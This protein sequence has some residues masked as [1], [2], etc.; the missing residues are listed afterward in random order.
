MERLI[1]RDALDDLEP[2]LRRVHDTGATVVLTGDYRQTAYAKLVPAGPETLGQQVGLA[3]ARK[4]LYDLA[5]QA[6]RGEITVLCARRRPLARL[7]PLDWTG[8]GPEPDRD[9][10][11]WAVATERCGAFIDH[12]YGDGGGDLTEAQLRALRTLAPRVAYDVYVAYAGHGFTVADLDGYTAISEHAVW[13]V[14]AQI[15]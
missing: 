11:L 2:L 9:P 7:V 14:R 13:L 4:R 12:R 3:E 1:F 10:E 5:Q 8:D 6:A 15:R